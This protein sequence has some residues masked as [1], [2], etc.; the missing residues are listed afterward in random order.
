M[1]TPA[2]QDHLDEYFRD[3][4]DPNGNVIPD[5]TDWD[6][7]SVTGMGAMFMEA[8][9]FNQDIS[10]WDTSS[11]VDSAYMFKSATSFDQDIGSWDTS[12]MMFPTRMFEGATSF[13]HDIGSWDTSS[14]INMEWMFSSA[15]SFDQDIG[16][17]DISSVWSMEGMFDYSGMS[18]ENFDATLIGWAAQDIQDGVNLGAAGLSYSSAS[19]DARAVLADA[20]WDID[21]ASFVNTGPTGAVTISGTALQGETLTADTTDLDDLDGLGSL[22]YQWLRDGVADRWCNGQQL[23]ACPG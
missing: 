19:A 5:I 12:S 13:N 18:T 7:S 4:T 3:G 2:P 17:W 1:S 11:V 20:G 8:S 10:S 23:Y 22:S 9:S 15:S 16:G 14:V 6:T 21:G